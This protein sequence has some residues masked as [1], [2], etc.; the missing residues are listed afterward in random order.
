MQLGEGG[1]EQRARGRVDA[2]GGFVNKGA[3]RQKEKSGARDT[4]GG[5]KGPGA[6]GAA[7]AGEEGGKEVGGE[8]PSGNDVA[9]G[10]EVGDVAPPT[11]PE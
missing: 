6:A 11:K 9:G 8:S 10:G 1:D 5:R 4:G 2:I 3:G 7:E